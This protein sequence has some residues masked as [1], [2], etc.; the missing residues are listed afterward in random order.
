MML[1]VRPRLPLPAGLRDRTPAAMRRRSVQSAFLVVVALS[2]FLL[3]EYASYLSGG[4]DDA[5]ADAPYDPT[6]DTVYLPFR[7]TRPAVARTLRPTLPLPEACLDAHIARGDL[8]YSPAEP[9]LDVLWTWVNGSDVLLQDAK[10]RIEA[11]MRDD[12]YRPNTSWKQVRQFRYVRRTL[13]RPVSPTHFAGTTTSCATRC[14][15]SWRISG[16]TLADSISLR[17]ISPS[18]HTLRISLFH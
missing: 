3:F 15:L 9:R 13:L 16:R 17:P 11:R 12:P 5:D 7:P 6:L 18:P 14:A 10:A 4:V 8:C 1:T 2:V